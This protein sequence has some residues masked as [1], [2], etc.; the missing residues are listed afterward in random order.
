MQEV[1]LSI[2]LQQL[3]M[4]VAKLTQTRP[5]SFRGGVLKNF[6]W[7]WLKRK[8][9]ELNI[10]RIEGL[11]NSQAQGLKIQSCQNFY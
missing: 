8:H 10:H 9:L 3:K 4:K 11:D 5:T 7:Y 1:G 6:W 2:N